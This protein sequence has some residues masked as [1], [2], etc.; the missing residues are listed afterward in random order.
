MRRYSFFKSAKLEVISILKMIKDHNS[1]MLRGIFYHLLY[2]FMYPFMR[3]KRIW[4]FQDR[5]DIADD[6]AKHLFSY[7]IKQDDDIKK[8]Y[9]ISKD[10]DDFSEMK[11]ID[12]NIVPL[13]SFKNRF[14]YLFAEKIICHGCIYQHRQ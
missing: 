2:L 5:V 3:G 12:K 10:C 4:L 11:K 8:Y 13:R 7:A 1:S 9:V 14:L 6:N